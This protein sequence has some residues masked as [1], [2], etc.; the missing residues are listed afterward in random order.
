MK[1]LFKCIF[2]FLGSGV[3]ATSGIAFCHSTRNEFGRKGE[4]S[5]LRL[6]AGYS[7]KLIRIMIITIFDKTRNSVYFIDISICN[8]HNLHSTYTEKITKYTDFAIEVKTQWKVTTTKTIP[9]VIP[10]YHGRYTLRSTPVLIHL[11]Y[12]LLHTL[13]YRKQ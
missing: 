8:T 4:R 1:H 3:E 9:I 6:G 12:D 13:F 11:K 2:P 10:V 5:V 7:V